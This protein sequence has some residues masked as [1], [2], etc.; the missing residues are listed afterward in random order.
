MAKID[1]F[2]NRMTSPFGVKMIDPKTKKPVKT[3]AKKTSTKKK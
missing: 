2:K 3:A 1:E